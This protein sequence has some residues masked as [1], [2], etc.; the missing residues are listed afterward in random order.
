MMEP[1]P[2]ACVSLI[3]PPAPVSAP[4]LTLIIFSPDNFT[5]QVLTGC[6]LELQSTIE[7]PQE[8]FSM[9][10]FRHM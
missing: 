1:V 10:T 3:L 6:E 9:P 2:V 4:A 5:I 8:K 7:H